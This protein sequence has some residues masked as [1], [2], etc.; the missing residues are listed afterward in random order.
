MPSRV[1]KFTKRTEK[2]KIRKA[3]FFTD[4]Y[5]RRHQIKN[6]DGDLSYYF[7]V[8]YNKFY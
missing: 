1:R 3:D 8:M 6:L 7:L 2:M 4:A 5:N